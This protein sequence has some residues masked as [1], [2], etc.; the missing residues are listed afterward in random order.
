MTKQNVNPIAALRKEA[1]DAKT[2]KEIEAVL[3]KVYKRKRELWAE[4][5][6]LTKIHTKLE[7]ERSEINR[8]ELFPTP[9]DITPERVMNLNWEEATGKLY[10]LIS[11]WFYTYKYLGNSGYVP[12]TKQPSIQVRFH[13]DQ[14]VE[15]Q[16]AEVMQF[17]PHLKSFE[18]EDGNR[19]VE[20][21]IKFLDIMEYTL[22]AGA[23]FFIYI[24]DHRTIL[25]MMRYHRFEILKEFDNV[26]DCL[27][28]VHQHHPYERLGRDDQWL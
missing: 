4:I 3:E 17:V 23:S 20:G 2:R 15:P 25:C 22:S 27:R 9:E 13:Q 8:Q 14:P 6:K 7:E 18:H 28:Y 1:K 21:P 19:R 24:Q 11:N 5:E 26:E 12:E 16:I 10:D